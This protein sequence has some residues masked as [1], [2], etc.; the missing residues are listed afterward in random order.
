MKKPEQFIPSPFFLK[1]GILLKD[2]VSMR[3][4]GPARYFININDTNELAQA[5]KW[6][7]EKKLKWIVIGDGTNLIPDDKGFSGLII[8]NRINKFNV[9]GN[10]V[11]LGAGNNL[12]KSIN[13]L[14]KLGL[15]GLEKM[16]GIP[17]SIGGAIYGCAGA[18]GQEIKDRLIRV[19]VAQMFRG[20]TSKQ[21]SK[22]SKHHVWKF[23][24]QT[25]DFQTWGG[26]GG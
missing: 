8:R 14:N 22:H 26:G 21:T 3:V 24:F 12:L 25:C 16:A 15:G 9:A 7:K 19:K 18:Y 6:A 11:T 4:G 17:G 20:S 2:I 13:R 23:D 1:R 10:Q 5:V